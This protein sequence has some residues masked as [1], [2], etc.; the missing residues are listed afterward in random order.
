M[1][2]LYKYNLK[3]HSNIY[4]TPK[5]VEREIIVEYGEPND[6]MN[7]DTGI[8]VLVP[9]YGGNMNSRVFQHLKE[10]IPDKY[11]MVVMQCDYFGNKCMHSQGLK[12]FDEI[13]SIDNIEKIN[14]TYRS[15][16]CDMG[17]SIHE[18]ND[19]GIM[20]A[21]DIVSATLSLL[22][23]LSKQNKIFDL[24]KIILFGTSHGAYISHLANIICPRLYSYILDVSSYIT[25]YYMNEDRCI[26]VQKERTK[27]IEWIVETY[28][29]NNKNVAYYEKLYNLDYLY[30]NFANTCGIIAFHGTEDWM[31]PVE[32]KRTFIEKIC[33]AEIV[34]ITPE[35]VDGKLF[36]NANHGLGADY[37]EL[38]DAIL[39][40]ISQK[41]ET[42]T[43]L[44]LDAFVNIN[45]ELCISYE[46]GMPKLQ[47]IKFD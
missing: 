29:K 8:L 10:I 45:D 13:L 34:I 18:F 17:E 37:F 30:S 15:A 6:G 22:R 28:I 7:V 42:S 24:N 25:P 43:K 31:V 5:T 19:M 11:N 38:L 20:Q 14:M 1:A 2:E 33:N 44:E 21:L 32:E 16:P 23:V 3:T 40:M 36:K 39:P 41:I 46:N 4:D 35:M 26:R 12:I 47:Y 27:Y 9:G